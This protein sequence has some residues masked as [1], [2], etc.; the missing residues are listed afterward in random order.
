MAGAVQETGTACLAQIESSSNSFESFEL[1]PSLSVPTLC[2]AAKFTCALYQ[3]KLTVRSL[4][5]EGNRSS[6]DC[7]NAQ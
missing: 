7:Y 2:N 1:C 3:V 5:Q 6:N 4:E